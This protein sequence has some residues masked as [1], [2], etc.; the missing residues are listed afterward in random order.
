[1]TYPQ[2]DVEVLNQLLQPMHIVCSLRPNKQRA[3]S[4]DFKIV[5]PETVGVEE[6]MKD[7]E[8]H[9]NTLARIFHQ[10]ARILDQVRPSQHHPLEVQPWQSVKH[11][12]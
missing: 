11:R 9:I 4:V 12:G 6:S 2:S 5:M 7:E 8:T 3:K 1:M 10:Y